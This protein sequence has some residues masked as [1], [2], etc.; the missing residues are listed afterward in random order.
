MDEQTIEVFGRPGRIRWFDARKGLGVLE[1]AGP[2][3]ETNSV[4]A[5]LR[6]A[7]VF[8]HFSVIETPG[9]RQLRGGQ[10]VRFDAVRTERGWK[11]T[12]VAPPGDGDG[13]QAGV[14]ACPTR[15][16]GLL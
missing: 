10:A 2:H 3:D 12:R 16:P 7:E 11:A 8:V 15:P 14:G 13:G 1:A 4:D 9:E 6:D 5:C